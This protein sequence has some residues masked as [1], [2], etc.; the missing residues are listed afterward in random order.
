MLHVR[1]PYC[2]YRQVVSQGSIPGDIPALAKFYLPFNMAEWHLHENFKYFFIIFTWPVSQYIMSVA[3]AAGRHWKSRY[4]WK[5]RP[6]RLLALGI[7]ITPPVL[8]DADLYRAFSS[9]QNDN[10][11]CNESGPRW[12]TKM[13]IL[14]RSC[15][16]F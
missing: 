15:S 10:W 5:P 1:D 3:A 13:M 6:L 4:K 14:L 12:R 8:T 2:F 11:T 7:V 9:W 16:V